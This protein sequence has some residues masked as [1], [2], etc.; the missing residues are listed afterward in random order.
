MTKEI[1]YT[2]KHA[3]KVTF[4]DGNT[5]TTEI[6]GSIESVADYYKTGKPFN[7]GTGGNDNVQ[8]VKKLKFLT[9]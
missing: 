9:N 2:R 5:I 1:D 4:E 7:I 8:K 6:N 3:V